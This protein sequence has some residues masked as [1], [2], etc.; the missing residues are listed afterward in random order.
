VHLW[1][2]VCHKERLA[3]Q[4]GSLTSAHGEL[5][6][7]KEEIGKLE[8]QCG[9]VS[10]L[11]TAQRET[12]SHLEVCHRDVCVKD[13]DR[14]TVQSGSKVSHYLMIKNRIKLY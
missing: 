7:L 11:E 1:L 4:S 8:K 3:E 10:Q 6:R 14:Y 2:C 5:A 12:I 13:N 9:D